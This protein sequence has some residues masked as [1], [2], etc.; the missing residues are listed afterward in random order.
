MYS[1]VNG[2]LS[3]FCSNNC[4]K[5]TLNLKRKSEKVK[6]TESYHKSKAVRLHVKEKGKEAKK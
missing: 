3:Y 6:W 4:E 5:Q 2:T 1:T